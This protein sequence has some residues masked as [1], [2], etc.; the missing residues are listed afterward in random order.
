M[1]DLLE[2]Y[3]L[4]KSESYRIVGAAMTVHRELGSGFLESVYLEAMEIEM[5]SLQIPFESQV[6]L[7]IFYKANPLKKKFA[8]DFVCFGKIIVELK[9][10]SGLV[11][12]HDSQVINY[13]K[14]TGYKLGLLINFGEES[15]S[16]K[17]IIK[18]I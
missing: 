7:N 8:A 10:L 6:P 4:Y 11:S 13:L 16:F 2:N 1:T 12:E 14:A 18:E 9:A 15:L 3:L 17:R 5:S